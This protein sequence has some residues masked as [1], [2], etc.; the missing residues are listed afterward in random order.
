MSRQN[1]FVFVKPKIIKKGCKHG[2]Q[3]RCQT[4]FISFNTEQDLREHVGDFQR[5][6]QWL[7]ARMMEVQMHLTPTLDPWSTQKSHKGREDSH[8]ANENSSEGSDE[9]DENDDHDKIGDD[10]ENGFDFGTDRCR[11]EQSFLTCPHRKCNK[12]KSNIS[13][14][15]RLALQRHFQ[16][17]V[18]CQELCVFCRTP[19]SRVQKYM[20]HS[21]RIQNNADE[22][23]LFY[24]KERRSQLSLHSNR[25]LD[26]MLRQKND[27]EVLKK[28]TRADTDQSLSDEPVVK[29]QV[30]MLVA[31][32]AQWQMPFMATE[33][34]NG[35]LAMQLPVNSVHG[36]ANNPG[37]PT[38]R[39]VDKDQD[40]AH[41][42]HQCLATLP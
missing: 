28:R 19:L 5:E 9:D 35:E 41:N 34:L 13:F 25:K 22:A 20:R 14:K 37:M 42:G 15:D 24:I 26:K 40:K 6:G 2:T 8:A 31:G 23:K 11:I 21:C 4:C 16:S 27:Q 38:I 10:D 32:N 29:R 33:S 1:K 30:P 12:T 17:H 18:W 3:P 39:D 7:A 36:F